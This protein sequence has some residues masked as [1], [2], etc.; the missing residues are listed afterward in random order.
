MAKVRGGAVEFPPPIRRFCDSNQ[1][2]LFRVVMLDDDRLEITPVL[3]GDD[4]DLHSVH[5]S[6]LSAE[7]RLWIPAALRELVAL[8]EQSVMMRVEDSTIRIYLRKVF[9]TLGFGP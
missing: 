2:T 7:G 1:W 4:S 3:P 9:K 5:L 8:G 6:S